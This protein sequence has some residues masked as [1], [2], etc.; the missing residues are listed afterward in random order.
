MDRSLWLDAVATE[1]PPELLWEDSERRFSRVWRDD[2]AGVSHPFIAV[3]ATAEHSTPSTNHRFVHEHA[4]RDHID[5]AWA[6]RPRELVR[7]GGHTCLLLDY[8]AGQPLDRIIGTPMACGRFLRIAVDDS[9][10]PAR[11]CLSRN[12]R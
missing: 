8:R 6:L 7:A 2:A 10:R 9:E 3:S 11:L 12:E 1:N 4:L 5:G